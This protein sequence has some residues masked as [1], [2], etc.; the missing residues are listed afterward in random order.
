MSVRSAI[1]S[2]ELIVFSLSNCPQCDELA[3]ALE[4]R[5]I[6]ARDVL[7]K[8]DKGHQHYAD[9]KRELGERL[10]RSEFTFPQTF[11]FGRHQGCFSEAKARIEAGAFDVFR[12]ADNFQPLSLK[13]GSASGDF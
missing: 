7:I 1:D 6:S 13:W 2:Q 4:A 9:L 12:C 11:A 8:W 3:L 5:G 10:G